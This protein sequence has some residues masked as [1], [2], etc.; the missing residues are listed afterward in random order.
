MG[1]GREKKNQ[2]Q[3]MAA[4]IQFS[5]AEEKKKIQKVGCAE[6]GNEIG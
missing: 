2:N 6:K 4:V 1:N 5:F 3:G